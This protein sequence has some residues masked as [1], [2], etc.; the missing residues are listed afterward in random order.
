MSYLPQFQVVRYRRRRP[1]ASMPI[2]CQPFFTSQHRDRT[3]DTKMFV[4]SH[5]VRSH[6]IP[7]AQKEKTWYKRRT[8]DVQREEKAEL[9][10]LRFPHVLQLKNAQKEGSWTTTAL[11][12]CSLRRWKPGSGNSIAN[13][14]AK[15]TANNK[16][17]PDRMSDGHSDDT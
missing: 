12:G 14:A 5:W 7:S 13:Y 3:D 17:S 11:Q 16:M 8:K 2:R 1:A 6:C 10:M 15:L 9:L 4:P